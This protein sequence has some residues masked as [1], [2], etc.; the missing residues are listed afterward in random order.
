M[1]E[2]HSSRQAG[3]PDFS[4]GPALFLCLPSSFFHSSSSR[5]CLR[6]HLPA[7]LCLQLF[8][9]DSPTGKSFHC[10]VAISK[11]NLIGPAHPLREDVKATAGAWG[12]GM[13][14]WQNVAKTG[15]L[16]GQRQNLQGIALQNPTKNHPL[17]HRATCF[18]QENGPSRYFLSG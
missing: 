18:L 14:E 6:G 9:L 4:L 12:R 10:I 3:P 7:S 13:G 17:A 11:R 8:Q 1:G 5:T 15:M 16:A 2:P